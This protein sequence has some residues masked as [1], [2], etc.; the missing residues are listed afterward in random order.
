[1]SHGKKPNPQ[2][3][4]EQEG[5]HLSK[6]EKLL[7]VVGVLTLIA[8][9]L[10][11]PE[12]RQ[13]LGL[14]QENTPPEASKPKPPAGSAEKK[15]PP[16]PKLEEP[17]DPIYMPLPMPEKYV[18]IPT[19]VTTSKEDEM[20]HSLNEIQTEQKRSGG[21]FLDYNE[22]KKLVKKRVEPQFPATAKHG[23][24]VSVEIFVDAKG[25]LKA[26]WHSVPE[27]NPDLL[28]IVQK[29]VKQW[30]FKPYLRNNKVPVP[31][32]THLEFRTSSG[33]QK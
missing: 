14:K 12:V 5:R 32:S 33:D 1:M 24:V 26:V 27:P 17:G 6:G 31:W 22:A 18:R 25:N 23:Q 30:K 7:T 29:A 28:D 16:T 8:A 3:T 11:V 20:A 10:V 15:D 9:A 13:F 4:P 19:I 21:E 2:K